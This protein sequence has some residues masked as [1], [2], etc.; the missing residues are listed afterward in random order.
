[1]IRTDFN[2][3]NKISTVIYLNRSIV[4]INFEKH[5]QNVIADTMNWFLNSMSD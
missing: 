1:M 5:I 4:I 2:A 3:R